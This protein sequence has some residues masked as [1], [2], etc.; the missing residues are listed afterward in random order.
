[1]VAV[2]PFP[3]RFSSPSPL[4][5]LPPRTLP[6][7]AKRC[8]AVPRCV[9][10]CRAAPRCAVLRRPWTEGGVG[11]DFRLNMAI[12]DKWIEVLKL[13]DYRRVPSALLSFL[14]KKVYP[15]LI[16]HFLHSRQVD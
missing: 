8:H 10:L 6:H 14:Q 16:Y 1:M 7:G 13:D 5:Q 2:A 4:A 15:L 3:S 11:F 9:M 12:A